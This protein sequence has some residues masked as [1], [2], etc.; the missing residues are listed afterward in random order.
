MENLSE[1][2]ISYYINAS[3]SRGNLA[4]KFKEYD[5]YWEGDVNRKK[6]E[7]DPASNTNIIHA[8]VEGQVSQLIEQ[9]IAVS[10]V[11]VTPDDVPF[12]ET[13][14]VILE[15]I[16]NKNKMV[17]TLD[18][19]ERRREKFGTGVLRVTFD[20]EALDGQ[21]I[22]RID[23]VSN[24]AVYV[25]PCITD[26]YRINEAE[27]VIERIKK[28]IYWAREHYGNEVADMIKPNFDPAYDAPDEDFDA[29][30]DN[31]WY[32]HLLVWT[33]SGGSL[34]LVEMTGCGIILSDSGEGFYKTSRYPYF[35]T[36][37]YYRENSIWGKGDVE[38]LKPLQDLINDLDDQIR[39]N[40]RLTGNPQRLIE[41]GSGIDLDALTNEAGLNIPVNH[42]NSVKNLDAP[43]LPPY[44]ENRRNAALQYESQKVIRFSDQMSGGGKQAG[45][46]T[47][48]EALAIQQAGNI[49]LVHKKLILQETLSEVFSYCLMLCEQFWTEE[50][51]FR[52][53]DKKDKFLYFTPSSLG[54]IID[55]NGKAKSA[56]FD[57]SVTVGAGMPKNNAF[58]YQLMTELCSGGII[59]KAEAR[60]YLADRFGLPITPEMPEDET[61]EGASIK[62]IPAND[63]EGSKLSKNIN[64]NV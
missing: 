19:H 46:S 3:R 44:I 11:P 38:L 18:I 35:F 33:N 48:T 7:N 14:R 31:D 4:D 52:I 41:T 29:E 42:V 56:Q 17:R 51:A 13:V 57:I 61:Q 28:S 10:A 50:M 16:L 62:T 58:I 37:L 64:Q 23:C 39:I 9:N 26:P 36:P 27:F 47:A 34:R 21:G 55:K 6:S 40:A 1:K 53:T 49:A 8:N 32:V 30:G 15:F 25:D 22:P 24:T 20:P 63:I 60:K 45:V 2:Y 43:P 54:E 5:R 12:S 59:T